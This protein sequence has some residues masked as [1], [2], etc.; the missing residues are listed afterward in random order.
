MQPVV[1]ASR[2]Q[3]A[4][5]LKHF[6]EG[7]SPTGVHHLIHVDDDE[8]IT[9]E[10]TPTSVENTI[11]DHAKHLR[12]DLTPSG[13]TGMR[14]AAVIPIN[15]YMGWKKE[16]RLNYAD[17][18]TWATFETMKINSSDNKNLRTGVNRL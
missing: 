17:V 1:N 6:H 3:K 5:K 18:Y 10:F 13:K 9:E 15:T 12:D 11:L 8:L 14:H 7:V 16:W 2:K 4:N